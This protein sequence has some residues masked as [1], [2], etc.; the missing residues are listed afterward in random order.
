MGPFKKISDGKKTLLLITSNEKWVKRFAVAVEGLPFALVWSSAEDPDLISKVVSYPDGFLFLDEATQN[1]WGEILDFSV[2]PNALSHS[3][4]LLEDHQIKEGVSHL[5]NGGFDFYLLSS[6][7]SGGLR[8]KLEALS[9]TLDFKR[10]L[11]NEDPSNIGENFH[12]LVTASPSMKNLVAELIRASIESENLILLGEPNSD[13]K[14]ISRIILDLMNQATG[15]PVLQ[16][17]CKRLSNRVPEAEFFGFENALSHQ[18]V[19][20]RLEDFDVSKGGILLLDYLESADLELQGLLKEVVSEGLYSRVIS[21]SN[22]QLLENINLGKFDKELFV[23][24]AEGL[25][26]IPPLRERK[27]DIPYLAKEFVKEFCQLYGKPELSLDPAWL[28]GLESQNWFGNVSELRNA[29]QS[30]VLEL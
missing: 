1:K 27:A 30:K 2:Y 18:A 26:E 3:V 12:G 17:N 5:K 15:L 24:L 22:H 13:K 4:L 23:L 7:A 29:V 19:Q 10:P 21:T 25:I 8:E 28:G 11:S 6:I 14:R 16:V 20:S 9:L